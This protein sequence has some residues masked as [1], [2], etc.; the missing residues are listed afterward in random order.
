MCHE[1]QFKNTSIGDTKDKSYSFNAPWSLGA[2]LAQ[3]THG[4]VVIN[5]SNPSTVDPDK[6]LRL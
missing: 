5:I 4:L 3:S 1:P 2:G 6:S